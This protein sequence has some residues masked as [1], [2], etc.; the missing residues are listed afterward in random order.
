MNPGRFRQC[1]LGGRDYVDA[2]LAELPSVR[3]ADHEFA[4][5][6]T[7]GFTNSV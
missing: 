6:R 7:T 4:D 3:G 1:G 2:K 5:H